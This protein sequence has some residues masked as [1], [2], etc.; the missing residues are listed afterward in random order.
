M[1]QYQDIKKAM[2]QAELEQKKVRL[3]IENELKEFVK[4]QTFTGKELLQ[5]KC[6]VLKGHH[7]TDTEEPRLE[8]ILDRILQYREEKE[9]E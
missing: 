1:S 4:A 8:Y 5:M 2:E 7:G 3:S 9:E 6:A